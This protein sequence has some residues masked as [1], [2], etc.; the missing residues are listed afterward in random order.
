MIRL[1]TRR[2]AIMAAVCT[3]PY[4][5]SF[6]RTNAFDPASKNWVRAGGKTFLGKYQNKQIPKINESHCSNFIYIFMLFNLTR[7]LLVSGHLCC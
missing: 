3:I 1:D 7:H 6:D 2:H 5:T 4:I